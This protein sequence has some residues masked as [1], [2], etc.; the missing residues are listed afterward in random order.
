METVGIVG[1][2]AMGSALLERMRLSQVEPLAYDVDRSALDRAREAG[3]E[4]AA[5]AA[6]V[7]R[8]ATIVD[9]V[10]RTDDEVLA[11]TTGERGVLEGATPGLLLLLHST[12][13][14]QT[15]QRV[16]EVAAARGVH[17]MDACMLSVPAAVRAGELT[18]VAGG[19][20]EDFQ[21]ARPHLLTMAK[22]ARHMGPLGTGNVAKLIA[23]LVGGAQTLV[24]A[25]AILLA[26][27]GGIPYV[28]ALEFLSE[29]RHGSVLD[30]WQNT[31]DASGKN[32]TPRVG[33]NTLGKDV[34]LARELSH[35]LGLDLPIIEQLGLAGLR[36]AEGQPH[37]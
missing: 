13:L 17:V 8:A 15:T 32:P 31:F 25:E 22:G 2:G 33:H 36:L 24:L 26:E 14:P 16:A 30:R 27:G 35:I 7:A 28:Q 34:P 29:V 1:V 4:P 19:S 12:I 6:E 3:A 10:V 37:P 5:S 9:V 23:N 18:F 11:C 21:R 20:D